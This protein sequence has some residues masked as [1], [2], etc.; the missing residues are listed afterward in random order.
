ME[1]IEIKTITWQNSLRPNIQFSIE[2]IVEQKDLASSYKTGELDV[3]ST[4]AG[5]I[6]MEQACIALIKDY[7]PIGAESVSVEINVKHLR[8]V[9]PGTKI[10]CKAL[11]KFIDKYKLF[12][13]VVIVDENHRS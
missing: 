13:D 7:L 4:P 10:I 9:K 8:A 2:K 12:F 6:I 1:N 5:I 3:L 11:L